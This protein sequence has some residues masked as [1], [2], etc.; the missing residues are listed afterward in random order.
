ML[1]VWLKSSSTKLMFC[2]VV[3]LSSALA[4]EKKAGNKHTNKK[5]KGAVLPAL[6]EVW[7]KLLHILVN[8]QACQLRKILFV[9]WIK[10][11]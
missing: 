10:E 7:A 4:L 11:Q 2:S 3:N 5:R 1:S 6:A 8:V 9:P